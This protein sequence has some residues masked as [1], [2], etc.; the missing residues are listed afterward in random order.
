MTIFKTLMLRE[1]LQYKRT[2]IG[3]L[4]GP[5][6]LL[7]V[8]VPFSGVEG[9]ELS[10][11]EPIAAVS[12]LMTMG[13]VA[14][15]AFAVSAYQMMGLPRRD[16]QDRSIEFWA[17]MPGSHAVSLAAPMLVHG[18]LVPVAALAA[19]LLGGALVGVAMVVSE[20]GWGA[21]AQTQWAALAAAGLWGLARLSVGLV[22]ATLWIAPITLALMAANAWLKRWGGWA[23]ML[24]VLGLD[25]LYDS[26]FI[27]PLLKEQVTGAGKS[28]FMVGRGMGVQL[29]AED[30]DS[31]AEALFR[32]PDW[33]RH[34]LVQVLGVVSDPHFLGGL[35]VA[36]LCFWLLV[37]QRRH[38]L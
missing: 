22:L 9:I 29:N 10:T 3:L 16:Q 4:V 25:K 8:L 14:V 15:L 2:W 6:L 19:G 20:M 30:P 38:S 7:L 36:G 12:A 32:F 21:L 24:A 31:M 23:L 11:P 35:V 37:L 33:A 1:W 34:D 5:A 17:S 18:L 27:L 13:L 28:F 26:R